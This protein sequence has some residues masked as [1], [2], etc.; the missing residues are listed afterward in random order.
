ML[1]L[2]IEIILI[3]VAVYSF[4]DLNNWLESINKFFSYMIGAIFIGVAVH[5]SYQLSLVLAN[6]L[7]ATFEISEDAKSN[8]VIIVCNLILV[9]L[10]IYSTY[11]NRK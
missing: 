2:L 8:I 5:M 7:Q 11:R 9:G 4:K 10:L 3:G 1:V 6:G